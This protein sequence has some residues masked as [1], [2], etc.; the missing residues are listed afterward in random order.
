MHSPAFTSTSSRT[1]TNSSVSDRFAGV[2]F[3]PVIRAIT[4]AQPGRISVIGIA[5]CHIRPALVVFLTILREHVE[6]L[7]RPARGRND[8]GVD[9]GSFPDEEA[10]SLQLMVELVQQTF[11]H[12]ALR[13][14]TAKPTLWIQ[15]A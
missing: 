11:L 14:A 3:V 2:D 4:L 15:S 7:E 6:H 13:E 10:A 9:D 5:D 12:I 8:A 1:A